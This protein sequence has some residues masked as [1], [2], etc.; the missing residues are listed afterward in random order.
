MN[1]LPG[2][3]VISSPSIAVA[4]WNCLEDYGISV[5]LAAS[6]SGDHGSTWA[7]LVT[8]QLLLDF[9]RGLVRQD[10]KSVV[11]VSRRT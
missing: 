6:S 10:S 4:V 7:W 8:C 2:A 3:I 11:C 1:G 9:R 5:T